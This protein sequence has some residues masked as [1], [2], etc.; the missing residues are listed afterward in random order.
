MSRPGALCHCTQHWARS[1]WPQHTAHLCA[2]LHL[3]TCISVL[4][5][6][7]ARPHARAFLRWGLGPTATAARAYLFRFLLHCLTLLHYCMSSEPEC[8]VT[9]PLQ[10]CLHFRNTLSEPRLQQQIRDRFAGHMP[11]TLARE[12]VV[13]VHRVRIPSLQSLPPNSQISRSGTVLK[14]FWG[15]GGGGGCPRGGPRGA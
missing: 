1:H 14:N 15:S 9:L 6:P 13:H 2:A 12:P 7:R 5:R 4:L 8:C 10:F 11:S 3:C